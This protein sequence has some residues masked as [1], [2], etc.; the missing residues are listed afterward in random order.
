MKETPQTVT[1]KVQNLKLVGL[2]LDNA[3]FFPKLEYNIKDS[4]Y[5]SWDENS[6]L[7]SEKNYNCTFISNF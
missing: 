5:L 7:S 1:S 4:Y 2:W 3:S 6:A